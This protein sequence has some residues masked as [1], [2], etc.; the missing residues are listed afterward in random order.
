ML[1]AHFEKPILGIGLVCLASAA[2]GA[3]RAP[4]EVEQAQT[5]RDRIDDVLGS[6]ARPDV[7][8]AEA[9][10]YVDR[11]KSQLE[12]GRV[13]QTERFPSWLSYRRPNLAVYVPDD[14]R[15]LASIGGPSSLAGELRH[16]AVRLS[17]KAGDTSGAWITVFRV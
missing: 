13:P 11:L 14:P 7:R 4:H 3:V 9:P 17:W 5:L 15:P 10:D 8:P 2:I 6:S 12:P 1:L 16:G